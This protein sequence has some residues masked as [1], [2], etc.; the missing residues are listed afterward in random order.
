MNYYPVRQFA[1][2]A[3]AQIA[4]EM[5]GAA[6]NRQM[7][8]SRDYFQL[9]D[10]DGSRAYLLSVGSCSVNPDFKKPHRLDLEAPIVLLQVDRMQNSVTVQYNSSKGY[11][12][13]ENEKS[14]NIRFELIL[15]NPTWQRPGQTA[16]IAI[17][18][19]A[20]NIK[21]PEYIE[22]ALKV[23]TIMDTV[24]SIGTDYSILKAKPG[25]I[26]KYFSRLWPLEL[27]KVDNEI[28][29]EIHS[30]LVLGLGC[31]A[32][33]LTGIALG[34]QFRGGHV[35]SAF[36]AS[37]LPGGVLVTFILSGKALTNNPSTPA[38]IGIIVMWAGL[39]VLLLLTLWI[40]R[41]LL[42]T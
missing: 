39:A 26:L 30:R 10:A 11:I 22:S 20:N 28:Y 15:E 12:T 31:I 18:K 4:I 42:R 25:R 40:Y 41:K 36:G 27:Q 3:R 19:Y 1:M 37:A 23:D 21:P 6:I 34:I 17:R 5:L 33:I 7:R 13:L 29:A 32:L 16:T 2:K 14:E 8:Q 24:S 9:E 38:R 35:L